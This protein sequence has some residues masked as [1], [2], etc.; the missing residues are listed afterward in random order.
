MTKI[1][2]ISL[3][4]GYFLGCILPLRVTEDPNYQPYEVRKDLIY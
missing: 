2:T 4:I 1:I 3:L